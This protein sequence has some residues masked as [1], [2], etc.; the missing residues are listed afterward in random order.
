MTLNLVD[1]FVKEFNNILK[2]LE[3]FIETHYSNPLLWI[4]I[5]ITILMIVNL[6]Y[7]TLS[8]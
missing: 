7:T 3:N 1:D 8:K 6:A 5:I 4:I 2:S